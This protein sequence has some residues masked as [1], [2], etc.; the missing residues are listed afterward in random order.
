LQ[1]DRKF[2]H[3]VVAKFASDETKRT[4]NLVAEVTAPF[5]V[6]TEFPPVAMPSTLN[7]AIGV[8]VPVALS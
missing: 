5:V 3:D 2:N 1:V 4:E 8:P 7:V 6:P